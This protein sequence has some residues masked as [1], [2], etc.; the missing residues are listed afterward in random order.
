MLDVSEIDRQHKE[1][2]DRFNLLH[3]AVQSRVARAEIYL[4]IDEIISYTRLHFAA[5]ERVMLEAGYPMLEQH[6]KKHRELIDDTLRLREKLN[7]VGEDLFDDWLNHWPFGRV[8]AHIQYAD[9]QI[10]DH[11][12]LGSGER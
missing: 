6:K 2:V 4:L 12:F 10:E 9:H 5:E 1:L 7:L 3:E 8:L 11:I